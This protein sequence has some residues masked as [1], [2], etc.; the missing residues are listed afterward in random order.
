[1]S[2]QG[3][4][5]AAGVGF[6]TVVD[7]D[8][9]FATTETNIPFGSADPATRPPAAHP[10][11][12]TLHAAAP[13]GTI[14]WTRPFPQHVAGIVP[15]PDGRALL[16]GAGPR[17]TD[18]RTD[19]YGALVLDRASGAPIVTCPT[20]GPAYFR[21]TWAPDGLGLAVSEAPFKV[22]EAVRGAY[23]VTVFR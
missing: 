23:R 12:F 17:T 21:P 7:G 8:V 6:G 11:E 22:G 18:D 2:S 19:L 20:E 5:I 13:D 10:A 9:V 16:V 14:R 15:S 4:P 3:V 1:V